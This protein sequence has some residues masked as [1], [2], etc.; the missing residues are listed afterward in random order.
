[1][2]A[3]IIAQFV[4][5]VIAVVLACT[6]CVVLFR[7]HGLSVTI[8]EQVWRR[9]P[10]TLSALRDGLL[11]E[12]HALRKQDS[13]RT[14]IN[15]EQLAILTQTLDGLPSASEE[16]LFALAAL[17]P[18]LGTRILPLCPL[19]RTDM[20]KRVFPTPGWGT[21]GWLW[22]CGVDSDKKSSFRFL[23]E[24]QELGNGEQLWLVSAGYKDKH[25]RFKV[26]RAFYNPETG[27]FGA[28]GPNEP[29]EL[30]LTIKDNTIHFFY[31][32]EYWGTL[33]VLMEGYN[34]LC[35]GA[36]GACAPCV[37]GVGSN[38]FSLPKLDARWWWGK[39]VCEPSGQGWAWVDRQAIRTEGPG[40]LYT[41]LTLN[42]LR[43]ENSLQ[44]LSRY[45]WILLRLN[46]EST[47]T[48]AV[49]A[50]PS[51]GSDT[52]DA[53]SDFPPQMAAAYYT[54]QGVTGSACV[55]V[56]EM[57]TM[58]PTVLVVTLF[59]FKGGEPIL[60]RIDCRSYGESYQLT[61]PNGLNHWTTPA[62]ACVLAA[63]TDSI[64]NNDNNNNEHHADAFIQARGFYSDEVM[65]A[66][67]L[68]T[69]GVPDTDINVQI[70]AQGDRLQ[71]PWYTVHTILIFFIGLLFF[72]IILQPL[73]LIIQS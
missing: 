37:D 29:V 22:A 5:L 18:G 56:E 73:F 3:S 72:Y 13:F 54:G 31:R 33:T 38:H 24:R 57:G 52:M 71:P 65:V 48:F 39:E 43:V 51:K 46:G 68:R 1:M 49:T 23:L 16:N 30:R 25:S 67:R 36:E 64:N 27:L 32:L 6:L 8:S 11:E 55:Q 2:T 7:D 63:P 19:Q 53:V 45:I 59:N 70:F 15:Y 34:V 35:T 69:A 9:E 10:A 60:V 58:V 20:A 17:L 41:A 4:G 28:G 47:T 50:T 61:G 14:P 12:M 44:N 26:L 40:S 21:R 62:D 42:N 66:S